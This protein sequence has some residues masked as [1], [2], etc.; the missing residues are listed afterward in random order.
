MSVVVC[1]FDGD[2][3]FTPFVMRFLIDLLTYST[4]LIRPSLIVAA[5]FL[6]VTFS[7]PFSRTRRIFLTK[8]NLLVK[9]RLVKL[10]QMLN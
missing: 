7:S 8:I 5:L 9:Y 3:N 4:N 2:T 1:L 6:W 10:F